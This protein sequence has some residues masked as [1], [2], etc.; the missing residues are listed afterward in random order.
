MI[1]LDFL[2]TSFGLFFLFQ[3]YRQIFIF[4]L[5]NELHIFFPVIV[6]SFS[7]YTGRFN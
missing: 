5:F 3:A 2:E 1:L 6:S 4:S 7:I